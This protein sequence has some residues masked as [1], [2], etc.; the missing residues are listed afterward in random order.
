MRNFPFRYLFFKRSIGL[1]ISGA[2]LLLLAIPFLIIGVAIKIDSKGPI[3]FRQPRVGQYRKTFYC[4]KFRSMYITAPDNC[5][6][7]LLANREQ[8]VTRVG[9]FLRKTS[10]DELPQLINVFLGDMSLVGPRPLVLSEKTM[11]DLREQRGIYK[12]R[13][14]I[15]GLAQISGRNLVT[16]QEKLY[17][18]REYLKH[19]SFWFDIKIIYKTILYVLARKDIY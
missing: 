17:Y 1:L 14:G 16:D 13:P 8:M 3:F 2:A 7:H 6:A 5:A 11:H 19:F 15:T 10:I 12:L 18:D 4:Y 9:A